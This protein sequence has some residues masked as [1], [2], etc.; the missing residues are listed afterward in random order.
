MTDVLSRKQRRFNMSRIRG[1]DTQPEIKL[2]R[3]LHSRGLRFRLHRRDLP[4]CPDLIFPRHRIVIFVHG[5]FWHRHLCPMFRWPNTRKAFWRQKIEGNARRDCTVQAAL[6]RA[7]W[8][9]LVV[10]ECA[11]RG[12]KRR[13]MEEVV[14]S[15]LRWFQGN[16]LI[17]IVAGSSRHGRSSRRISNGSQQFEHTVQ[18]R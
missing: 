6:V 4:G 8:R 15:I 17:G 14:E 2:R 3:S 1:R 18:P 13:T 10:W 12:P 16:Q 7:N 5:C 11:L 9:V